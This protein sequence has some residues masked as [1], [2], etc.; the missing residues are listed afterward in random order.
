MRNWGHSGKRL[1]ASHS[2][3]QVGQVLRIVMVHEVQSASSHPICQGLDSVRRIASA[4]VLSGLGI[5]SGRVGVRAAREHAALVVVVGVGL[6]VGGSWISASREVA[7]QAV[8]RAAAAATAERV[9]VARLL[10]GNWV[11]WS[12]GP[13]N[14]GILAPTFA[15][16]AF[17][18]FLIRRW[19]WR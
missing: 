10:V 18:F 6:K 3:Q 1:L 17:T 4:V 7:L 2:D 8:L 9:V 14:S 11:G 12:A 15:V 16:S 13:S 19:R 5:V